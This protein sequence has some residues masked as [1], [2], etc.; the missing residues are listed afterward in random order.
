MSQLLLARKRQDGFS[1][2]ELMVV[3]AIVLVMSL[4]IF[5]VMSTSEGKKRTLTSVNDI[6][7]SGNFAMYQLE[8]TVRIAGSGF[9]QSYVQSFGCQLFAKQTTNGVILPFSGATMAQ[10]FN[11]LNAALGGTF[12][13]A[14][15]I[16]AKNATTPGMSGSTSD[17]LI[18]MSG[19][20]G[21]GEVP[22]AFT[23]SPTS[24]QLNLQSTLS[25]KPNDL[26]LVVDQAGSSGALPCMIQQVD[27]AYTAS[28]N[29]TAL[30]LAGT[31]YASSIKA[32]GGA[33][34][35]LTDYSNNALAMGIGNSARNPP[36]FQLLGVG[37][38]NVLF[39]Y[40][41]LQGGTYDTAIPTADGV[42]EMHAL[43]GV[44]TNNDG[45]VDK[46]VDPSTTGYDYATLESGTVAANNTLLTI[47]AIRIGLIMRTS[48]QEK[49]PV[50]PAPPATTGPLTLF[51][52]LGK[53][54][55]YT[56]TL[57]TAEQ[58]YRYRTIES[59]IPL[60]NSLLLN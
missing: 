60:R 47:K 39:Q 6:D 46:W 56:R 19:S 35:N 21:Y 28:T 33:I 14:P 24:A 26:V 58:N 23:N 1:L 42:F 11:T 59:T 4:A 9:S 20:A 22:T 53:T 43:Y 49:A 31:Y 17:A 30:P 37:D 16:I 57:T 8:K 52:D 27:S 12:V 40:D 55:T 41:L 50:S 44:D 29:A 15:A 2:I 34:R 5:G 54:L 18:I 36:S 51:S 3:I 48:L 10:P 25:F 7:Q 38:N 45:L 32:K 13:L